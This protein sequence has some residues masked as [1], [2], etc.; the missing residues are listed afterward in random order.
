MARRH[1]SKTPAPMNNAP[2]GAHGR[3][4][5]IGRVYRVRNSDNQER[6][7]ERHVRQQGK[8][9]IDEQTAEETDN[10]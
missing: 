6:A 1:Q 3:K 7:I 2:K 5:L 10:G 4:N 9:I 8:K